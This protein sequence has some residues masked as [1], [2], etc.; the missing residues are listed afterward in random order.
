MAKEDHAFVTTKGQ[1]DIEKTQDKGM[2][3]A[4]HAE[5]PLDYRQT[6]LNNNVLVIGGDGTGKSSSFIKPNILQINASFVITDPSGEILA[7]TGK[8]LYEH[9]YKIKIFNMV[10][11]KHSNH[12]NPLD[13]LSDEEDV[14]NV[15]NCFMANTPAGSADDPFYEAA[16]RILLA[17]CIFYLVN[18]CKD[19]T[20]R[21]MKSVLDMVNA[22]LPKEDNADSKTRL[23]ELFD[24]LPPDDIACQYYKVFKQASGKALKFIIISCVK[25]LQPFMTE[26]VIN[27]TKTDDLE[28]DKIDDEKTALFIITPK[29]DHTFAFLASM[30]YEQLFATLLRKEEQ[31]A[32]RGESLRSKYHVRCLMDEFANVGRIPNL[33]YKLA[34]MNRDNISVA[35]VIQGI[36][37]LSKMYGDE[38]QSIASC[39]DSI[40]FLGSYETETLEYISGKIAETGKDGSGNQALQKLKF[41]QCIVLEKGK[42]AKITKKYNYTKHPLYKETG[43]YD[44]GNQFRYREVV[45][46]LML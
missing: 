39:C 46:H 45:D 29:A 28:L 42:S 6:G 17:A 23:D 22:A 9:G 35:I 15:I 19:E 41:G 18:D 36:S 24:S 33:S 25:R 31:R 3:L 2:I 32:E 38:W 43:D 8:T 40:V 27:L 12:Y 13:L 34:E 30:L 44:A 20:K 10:D 4:D 1:K 37:Q 7:A 5:R 11:A 21:N 26:P 16:E 14:L